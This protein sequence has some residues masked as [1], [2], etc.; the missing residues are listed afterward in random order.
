MVF[1]LF[2][3]FF[4]LSLLPSS[5][6]STL[7]LYYQCLCERDVPSTSFFSQFKHIAFIGIVL[8]ILNL[9]LTTWTK[10][11]LNMNLFL[12]FFVSLCLQ[13]ASCLD[14]SETHLKEVDMEKKTKRVRVKVKKRWRVV[15]TLDQHP[16]ISPLFCTHHWKKQQ[17][18]PQKKTRT[19]SEE[20]QRG[21]KKSARH[22]SLMRKL[23]RWKISLI[24]KCQTRKESQSMSTSP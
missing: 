3:A 6:S 17:Q 24:E 2:V 7:T 9:L 19:A 12:F 5:S 13:L 20:T 8:T 15:H 23:Y 16:S 18:Q 4:S 22:Y 11:F 10:I 14:S 21:K 1:V